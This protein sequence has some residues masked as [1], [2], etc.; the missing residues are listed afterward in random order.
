MV[1]YETKREIDDNDPLI[2]ELID[3]SL[4]QILFI[5]DTILLFIF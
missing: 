3:G 4:I 1:D 5:H 2:I